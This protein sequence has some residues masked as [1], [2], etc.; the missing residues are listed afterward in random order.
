MLPALLA[1]LQAR[2][3]PCTIHRITAE[4]WISSSE[5]VVE[6]V[7]V[8]VAVDN[9]TL[10]GM[11]QLLVRVMSSGS[12]DSM[13][14]SQFGRGSSPAQTGRFGSFA[15]GR[16]NADRMVFSLAGDGDEAAVQA[17]DTLVPP[18]LAG[19][20]RFALEQASHS[21]AAAQ[22]GGDG[23]ANTF[24]SSCHAEE[25][26]RW[27]ARST[28]LIS[29]GGRHAGLRLHQHGAAWLYL[30]TG[31]KQ[32]WLAHPEYSDGG[33]NQCCRHERSLSVCAAACIGPSSYLPTPTQLV[34][35]RLHSPRWPTR[36]L[37]HQ[38]WIPMVHTGAL[39]S[40]GQAR[41]SLCLR[42]RSVC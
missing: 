6:P 21:A 27:R 14:Y 10:E 5:P 7:L 34:R 25:E 13:L 39:S 38:L 35:R 33:L 11:D 12:A 41:S 30:L 31:V 4:Q 36:L 17:V 32:W 40:S 9:A 1:A 42:C 15:A 20:A 26:S 23:N 22:C 3:G 16:E 19:R 28:S 37:G 18:G 8:D 24:R 29:A 2:S